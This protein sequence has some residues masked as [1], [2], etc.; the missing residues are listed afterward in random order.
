MRFSPGL[1]LPPDVWSGLL[2]FVTYFFEDCESVLR[3]PR[4]SS[5]HYA[6]PELASSLAGVEG[7][8]MTHVAPRLR[9]R[10]LCM[11]AAKK[12][13]S[14]PE[15]MENGMKTLFESMPPEMLSD[16]GVVLAVLCVCPQLA[17]KLPGGWSDDRDMAL[18]VVQSNEEGLLQFFPRFCQDREFVLAAVKRSGDNLE[19]AASFSTDREIVI[20]AVRES[21]SSLEWAPG[22]CNDRV[23]ALEALNNCESAVR[24][25]DPRLLRTRDFLVEAVKLNPYVLRTAGQ[26][27]DKDLAL[28]AVRRFPRLGFRGLSPAMRAQADVWSVAVSQNPLALEFVPREHCARHVVASA[29]AR[30]PRAWPLAPRWLRDRALAL[31]VLSTEG[32]MLGHVVARPVWSDDE[33]AVCVAVAQNGLALEFAS[34]RLRDRR[35]VVK[36]AVRQN[37]LALAFASRRLRDD[38]C[39]VDV[40]VRQN[41]YALDFSNCSGDRERPGRARLPALPRA[42][43]APWKVVSEWDE[44]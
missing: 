6:C 8:R 22:L 37:G 44:L 5:A 9:T 7:F 21:G 14:H 35:D 12:Y 15:D 4:L 3:L 27:L 26:W 10:A 19:W 39:V 28:E 30:D 33:E 25:V 1:E 41:F 38:Y 43:G 13:A 2:G 24:Y 29:V 11:R 34:E 42:R 18:A 36:R 23:V 17:Q 20:A 16:R 40:A 31:S 32:L